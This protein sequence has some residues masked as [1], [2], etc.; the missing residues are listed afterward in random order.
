MPLALLLCLQ[1]RIEKKIGGVVVLRAGVVALGRLAL[2]KLA[3]LLLLR[4][5]SLSAL[6]VDVMAP[7]S[8]RHPEIE[9]P[10]Y[11]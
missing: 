5:E 1:T 8:R 7:L 11:Q 9:M 10:A 3:F 6:I 4:E 2:K